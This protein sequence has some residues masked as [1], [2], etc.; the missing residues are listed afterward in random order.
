MKLYANS[1]LRQTYPNSHISHS[2]IALC[3][4]LILPSRTGNYFT[5]KT[6]RGINHK[7]PVLPAGKSRTRLFSYVPSANSQ[8]HDPLLISEVKCLS[9]IF[10][11]Y[12]LQGSWR[13]ENLSRFA[14]QRSQVGLVC[15]LSLISIS[16]ILGCK[17]GEAVAD[18]S[19]PLFYLRSAFPRSKPQ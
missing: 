5:P 18:R 15:L 8:V 2:V 9:A 7:Q 10:H 3:H 14:F 17:K 19:K 1:C 4:L 13:E 6:P 16:L 11:L 12:Y